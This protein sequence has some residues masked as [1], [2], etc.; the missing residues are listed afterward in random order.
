[1]VDVLEAGLVVGAVALDIYAYK[2]MKDAESQ[3]EDAVRNRER[4]RFKS[5]AGVSVEVHPQ[6]SAAGSGTSD[7]Q[8]TDTHV[9][10]SL[11]E[12]G[13]EHTSAT[14]EW[15]PLTYESVAP[16]QHTNDDESP[17]EDAGDTDSEKNQHASS[18]QMD[19]LTSQYSK[20]TQRLDVIDER[21]TDQDTKISVMETKF[22]HLDG[23][24]ETHK[25]NLRTMSDQLQHIEIPQ[26]QVEQIVNVKFAKS[27][28][29]LA[30]QVKDNSKKLQEIEGKLDSHLI[31]AADAVLIKRDLREEFL[32]LLTEPKA[33]LEAHASEN[34]KE[35]KALSVR[36]TAARDAALKEVQT[37]ASKTELKRVVASIKITTSKAQVAAR[38]SSKVKVSTA[39]AGKAKVSAK[40]ANA[41][42]TK[43]AASKSTKTTV[44]KTTKTTTVKVAQ[45]PKSKIQSAVH[46]YAK[47]RKTKKSVKAKS[48]SGNEV[49][50]TTSVPKGTHVSTEVNTGN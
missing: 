37:K 30:S 9:Q 1:M 3:A 31:S 34:R 48:D 26:D 45:K 41:D 21:I 38:K 40:T 50:V 14:T 16:V 11:T 36:I 29:K 24:S 4:D 35:F 19:T 32:P 46:E 15:K 18:E 28:E 10:T 27:N 17:H 13:V 2:K 12:H 5:S 25:E 6:A 44:V 8:T 39:V 20:I 22:D 43:K 42:K 47:S 33:T 7:T 23:E 49:T